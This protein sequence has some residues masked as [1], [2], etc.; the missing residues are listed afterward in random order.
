MRLWEEAVPERTPT[1]AERA[2]YRDVAYPGAKQ[3]SQRTAYKIPA[4]NV[5]DRGVEVCPAGGREEGA[6]VADDEWAKHVM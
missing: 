5:L 1:A 3:G 6:G 4:E 2:V